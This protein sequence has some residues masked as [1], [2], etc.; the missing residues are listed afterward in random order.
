MDAYGWLQN[1][2]FQ[3]WHGLNPSSQG[4]SSNIMKNNPSMWKEAIVQ[5]SKERSLCFGFTI[6]NLKRPLKL[7]YNMIP[8]A[9]CMEYLSTFTHPCSCC[10]AHIGKY[11]MHGSIWALK[12][13]SQYVANM[14]GH[15]TYNGHLSIPPI[16]CKRL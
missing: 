3:G 4:D 16:R 9:F 15:V 11:S 13:S 2:S 5:E 1:A 12:P 6:S 14:L 10:W 8:N 7:K